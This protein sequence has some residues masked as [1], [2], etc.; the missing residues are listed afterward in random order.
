MTSVKMH[1]LTTEEVNNKAMSFSKGNAILLEEMEVQTQ[2]ELDEEIGKLVGD[3][4]KEVADELGHEHAWS[5]PLRFD[6]ELCY[7][8]RLIKMAD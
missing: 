2:D 8:T 5:D 4:S 3:V 7:Q 6:W 1:K